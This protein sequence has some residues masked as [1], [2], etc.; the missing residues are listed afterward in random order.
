MVIALFDA[1]G[2][3]TDGKPNNSTYS[4]YMRIREGHIVEATALFDSVESFMRFWRGVDLCPIPGVLDERTKLQS[5]LR[6]TADATR[7]MLPPRTSPTAKTPGRLVSSKYGGRARGQRAALR[8]SG[9]R[10][11]PV[12][13][14][15]LASSATQPSSQRVFGSAPVM[16]NTWLML[17]SSICPV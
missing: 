9:D 8:S 7:L 1:T 4:R 5:I 13:M 6:P 12:L 3:A 11:G 14:K 15:P 2:T 17:C 10:S 16:T